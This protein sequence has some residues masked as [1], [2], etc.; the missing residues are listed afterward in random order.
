LTNEDWD[1]SHTESSFNSGLLWQASDRDTLRLMV[2]RGVQL[3]NLLNLGALLLPVP[4]LGYV[5]G[6]PSLEPTVVTNYEVAWDRA[7]PAIGAELHVS[8]FHGHTHAIVANTGG[9]QFALG[10]FSTSANIGRSE[11]TGLEISIRGTM[12]DT[13]RWGAS[14]TPQVI[15]DEFDPAFTVE[16]TLVDFEHT[17]PRHVLNA[18][19][20]W[21]SGP[22]EV[23]GYLRY[24]S[25]FDGIENSGVGIIIG[26]LAP[27][28]SYVSVDARVGYRLN[29]RMTL[30]LSGQNLID[31]PQRQTA[32]PEVER[33]VFGTF[34][35]RL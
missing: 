30:A 26:S 29:D 12:G 34:T 28:S 27:I 23:D 18:N 8:L 13:W 20:G 2:G 10:L 11:T 3:P 25:R 24:Q 32:A 16:T 22:W 1:R 17:T 35:M 15:D 21:S 31:S 14:Y 4:G 19:L 5:T 6:L 9:A 7:L 33:R